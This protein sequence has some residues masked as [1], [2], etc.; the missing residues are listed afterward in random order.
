MDQITD[1]NFSTEEI[2]TLTLAQIVQYNFH[3]AAIFEKYGLDFCC[4]G[5]KPV[6]QAC[7]E[8]GLNKEA[9]F[10]EL[11][12][13]DKKA[14]GS[15]RHD[16]WGMDFMIDFIVNTHHEYVRKMIPVI[17]AHTQKIA[18]VHGE[19]HPEL[20]EIAKRFSIVYKDLKQHMLKEEQILFPY[21]KQMVKASSNG[22]KF[23]APY[24]GSVVNPIQMMEIEHQNAGDEL[25]GIRDLSNNYTV[26]EDACNT[27]RICFLELKEFEEDLHKHIHLENNILF[28]KA[29]KLEQEMS[30]R[31]NGA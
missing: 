14:S 16:E 17:S 12:Y 31:R 3:A 18:S 29:V 2:G 13:L 5:N 15:T 27:Y 28:P 25:F 21:V 10:N 24:F 11:S 19:N 4:R 23:E 26:P 7:E 20:I 6:A 9:I 30:L 22:N 8:K 1:Y